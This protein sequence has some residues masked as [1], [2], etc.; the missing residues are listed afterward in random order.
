MIVRLSNPRR[1]APVVSSNSGL[2][3]AGGQTGGAGLVA[4]VGDV[5][6]HGVKATWVAAAALGGD[7][8]KVDLGVGHGAP[9]RSDD[10]DGKDDRLVTH[11]VDVDEDDEG[12]CGKTEA[13]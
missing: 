11:R 7:G 4:P 2:A 13:G 6:V 5:A 9:S 3:S 10:V 12:V 8:V 1:A